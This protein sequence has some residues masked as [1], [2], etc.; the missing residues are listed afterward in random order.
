MRKLLYSAATA[1][2]LA[3][4]S[5]A[6][7]AA[8]TIVGGSVVNLAVPTPTVSSTGLTI[9]FGQ[10]PIGATQSGAFSFNTDGSAYLANILIGSST[11]GEI[12]T[13]ALL[14]GPGLGSVAFTPFT[15]GNTHGLSASDIGLLAGS[16]YNLSFTGSGNNAAAVTGSVSLTARPAVPEPATWAMMLLGFAGIGMTIRRRQRPHLAQLA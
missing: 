10:E 6:A 16:T 5:T 4:S 1:A 7:N 2:A 14:T 8:V 9:N 11:T 13:G 3:L 15:V 12:I